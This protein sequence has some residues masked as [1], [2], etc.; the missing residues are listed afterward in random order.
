MSTADDLITVRRIPIKEIRKENSV[1][2]LYTELKYYY[3][4]N[5]YTS[6]NTFICKKAHFATTIAPSDAANGTRL[7]II[8]CTLCLYPLV[9]PARII[10][11]DRNG[12]ID[13]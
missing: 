5:N 4:F 2:T 8:V 1:D 3:F 7:L 12:L 6:M 10:S 13:R 9:A 11:G